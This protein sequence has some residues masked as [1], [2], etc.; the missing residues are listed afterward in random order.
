M[1]STLASSCPGL[2]LC[3][4]VVLATG[5]PMDLK[6]NKLPNGTGVYYNKSV[7]TQSNEVTPD[8]QDF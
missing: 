3:H 1:V 6:S 2:E 7:S 4:M 5:T 8:T